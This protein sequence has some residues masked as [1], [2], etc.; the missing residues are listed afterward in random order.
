LDMDAL[1]KLGPVQKLS[2]KELF[3][4]DGTEQ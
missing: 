3:G 4:F 1:K 2:L